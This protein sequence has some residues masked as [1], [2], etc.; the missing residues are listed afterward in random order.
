MLSL[1]LLCLLQRGLAAGDVRTIDFDRDV[2]PILVARCF[3][4]HGPGK[5]EAGLRLS[6]ATSGLAELESGHRAVVPGYPD[7]SELLRRIMAEPAE[8]MPPDSSL[9]DEQIATLREWIAGGAEWP[10]HWAYRP[11]R[12]ELPPAVTDS[13]LHE[14]TRTPV[15]QF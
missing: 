12:H 15:D 13:T 5:A 11:L 14:W 4:C 9:S 8:R 3:R 7:A 2:R 6:D 1:L 10:T